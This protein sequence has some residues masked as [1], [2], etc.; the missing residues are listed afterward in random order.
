M[1]A[2][3]RPLRPEDVAAAHASSFATFGELDARLGDPV[4]EHTDAVRARGEHRVAHLQRTDPDGAWAAEVDGRL[5]GVAL[6]LRR[7][8]LWFLS[9]LTV[10]PGLQGQGVGARLLEAALR[11][12]EDASAG[13]IL[14]TGDPKA[15][16]RYAAAGFALHPGYDAHGRVDRS[17]LPA[18]LDVQ[19]GPVLERADLVED[20]VGRLRGVGY[21]PE[22]EAFAANDVQALVAEDGA[23]RGFCLHGADRVLSVG[24]TTPALAHRLLWAGLGQVE[25]EV[26]LGFLT[27]DQQWAIE[28]ALAARLTV[29]PGSSSCRRGALG[30]L[31]PYLPT[32]AYG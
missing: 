16:R 13:W 11:T 26:S 7:G 25:G 1:T 24:A 3:V 6:A 8:P 18:G 2:V 22:L 9:L 4:P 19:G 21:G 29:K 31:T 32:G 5:V 20:V 23:E 30:P 15:L 28:V 27:G 17:A 14:A 12:S 10:E